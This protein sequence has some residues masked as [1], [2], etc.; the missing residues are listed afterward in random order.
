M[1]TLLQLW[2][3]SG[4]SR[5]ADVVFK[6]NVKTLLWSFVASLSLDK[7]LINENINSF[8]LRYRKRYYYSHNTRFLELITHFFN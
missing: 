8:L 3:K 1:K 7:N 5:A 6:G 4:D 2:E